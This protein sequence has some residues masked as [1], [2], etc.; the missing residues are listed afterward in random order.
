VV[1]IALS[2]L[3]MMSWSAWMS[4][5]QPLENKAVISEIPAESSLPK[6]AIP[7]KA[8]SL[9][10]AAAV[11]TQELSLDNIEI[12]F[13]EERAGIQKATFNHYK[14][15]ELWLGRGLELL[16][17]DL[18]FKKSA[19]SPAKVEF[20]HTDVKKTIYK[21]FKFLNNK[22]C[23]DLEINVQND[24]AS[25]LAFDWPLI[26]GDL[27][28]A[29]NPVEARY[30]GISLMTDEKL[31]HPNSRKDFQAEVIKWAGIY[32]RYFSIIIEP[33]NMK[34]GAGIKKLDKNGSQ[35]YLFPAEYKIPPGRSQAFKFRIYLGP[36]DLQTLSS[37]NPDW[38]GI[39]HY[40]VFN[41]VGHLLL[42]LLQGIYKVVHNWGW[43]IIILSLIIYLCLFPLT[44]KQMHS[45]KEM[46]ALQPHIEELRKQYKDNP[47]K[48]NKEIMQLYREHKV[49]PL[50]GCLPMILQI[51]VFFALY[52]VL[53]RS[54]ALR[55][56]HFLWIKDLSEPDRLFTLPISLPLL[57]N[58]FNIL[59]IIMAIGMF[60]QQKLTSSAASGTSSE[61][62][63][64][65]TIF[66]PIMFG[67]IFYKMPSG[68]VLYWFVNSTLMLLYQLR[69]NKKR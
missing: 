19:F 22:Y 46:Q 29:T 64:F 16:G 53:M 37:I 56:S 34:F 50:G 21:S 8:E 44:L 40:G 52:Q 12:S 14:K 67:M 43:A 66:F 38:A 23:I 39:M 65:M 10:V 13:L 55:G 9:P 68:L 35:V 28:F 58:E 63:R 59:P 60:F 4:K 1:A 20:V 62:Q 51:P 32:N 25:P 2:L 47:Q 15:G 5:K 42:Q 27:D 45:M 57:G 26:L 31:I 48:L 18:A 30:Y 69:L 3:V 36:Q 33:L 41:F 17:P 54:V 24:S 49:N 11:K 61:Q 6:A 7:V